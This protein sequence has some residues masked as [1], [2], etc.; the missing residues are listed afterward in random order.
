M[1]YYSINTG[2]FTISNPVDSFLD[3]HRLIKDDAL[4]IWLNAWDVRI[5]T[6]ILSR[7]V[8][9]PNSPSLVSYSAQLVWH[10]PD[11]LALLLDL[12][13]NPL[14][15]PPGQGYIWYQGDITKNETT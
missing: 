5:A 6:T 10:L 3:I 11:E 4:V 14:P 15:N 13:F 9:I 8:D 2:C 7:R 12:K 1:K